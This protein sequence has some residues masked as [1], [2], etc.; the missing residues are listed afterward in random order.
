MI[1]IALDIPIQVSVWTD[2]FGFQGVYPRSGI[3]RSHGNSV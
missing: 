1:N 2:V 3:A